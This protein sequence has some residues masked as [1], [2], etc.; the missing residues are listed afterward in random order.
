M[1][2]GVARAQGAASGSGAAKAEEVLVAGRPRCGWS[3][4]RAP[5]QLLMA[6]VLERARNGG[7]TQLRYFTVH[8]SNTRCRVKHAKTIL[9]DGVPDPIED[10][11]RPA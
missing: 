11:V 10:P 4:R 5:R 9:Q 6:D 3:S 8:F 1:T 7:R 2:R